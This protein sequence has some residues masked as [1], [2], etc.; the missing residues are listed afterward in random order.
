MKKIALVLKQ[1]AQG[2]EY[3]ACVSDNTKTARSGQIQHALGK[4]FIS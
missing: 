2:M 3:A 1:T 4:V